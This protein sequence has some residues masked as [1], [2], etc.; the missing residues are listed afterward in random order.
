[1]RLGSSMSNPPLLRIIG[2]EVGVGGI[3]DGV[4]VGKGVEVSVAVRV[5]CGGIVGRNVGEGVAVHTGLISRVDAGVNVGS[6]GGVL[7]GVR[8]DV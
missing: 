1:M 6:G 5:G 7:A 4:I 2:A 3:G 8:V